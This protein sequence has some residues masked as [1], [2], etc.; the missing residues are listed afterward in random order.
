[1]DCLGSCL[2]SPCLVLGAC[3]ARNYWREPFHVSG[4]YR[5]I[6]DPNLFAPSLQRFYHLLDR[7]NEQVGVGQH[8]FCCHSRPPFTS[9]LLG[10]LLPVFSDEDCANQHIQFYC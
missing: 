7:P 10:C 8:L 6:R 2:V 5:Q 3:Q 1:M 9:A 4:K